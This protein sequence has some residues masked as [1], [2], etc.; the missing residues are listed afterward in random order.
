M[1][2]ALRFKRKRTDADDKLAAPSPKC[3]NA[4][5]SGQVFVDDYYTNDRICTDCGWVVGSAWTVRLDDKPDR[6]GRSAGYSIVCRGK[7]ADYKYSPYKPDFYAAELLRSW[8]ASDPYI[9]DS[10]IDQ[11]EETIVD[12]SQGIPG[13][14]S[15]ER[16]RQVCGY[17]G[18][19]NYGERWWQIH[20]RLARLPLNYLRPPQN[21][22]AAIKTLFVVYRTTG[23][24]ILNSTNLWAPR[25]TL[26]NYCYVFRQLLRLIDYWS[27][28]NGGQPTNWYQKYGHRFPKLKTPEKIDTTDDNWK[29]MCE[30][31]NKNREWISEAED[32]YTPLEQRK[33]PFLPLK[34]AHVVFCDISWV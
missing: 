32:E 15:R 10:F 6:C 24:Y 23:M 12:I 13:L 8:Q 27:N 11:V 4:S 2:S 19:A 9:E 17:L 18:K 21:L 1:P 3:P 28:A 16:I 7:G 34:N 22:V 5:C 33:W 26:L 20:L 14:A 25:K 29:I 30:H 31:V